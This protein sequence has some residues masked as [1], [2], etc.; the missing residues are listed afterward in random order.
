[1]ADWVESLSPAPDEGT[2]HDQP[3]LAHPAGGGESLPRNTVFAGYEL[4]EELGRGGMGVVYKARQLSLNRTVALKMVLTGRFVSE[5][6]VQRF[7]AEAAAAARL[8]HPNIVT[9]HEVG[10]VD[11]QYFYTMELIEGPSLAQRV[12]AGPLPGRQA[13]HYLLHIARAIHHAHQRGVLHRDLKPSNILLDAD[14]QPHVA[15]FGLA[16]HLGG[17]AAQTRSGALLGTPSYMAPEQASGRVRSLG[18]ACD[19]YGLGAV[20]YELITGQPPFLADTPLETVRLVL[21]REPAPPKL[22]NPDI[23]DDLETICLKCLEKEPGD[24]YPSAAELAADLERYLRGDAIRAG[25]L[26]LFER[27]A[28][29]LGRT[30][31]IDEFHGWGTMLYSFALIVFLEHLLVFLYV[32]RHSPL[33]RRMAVTARI[34][35]F[36]SM[37]VI[38]WWKRRRMLLPTSAAERQLWATWIGYI[39]ACFTVYLVEPNEGPDALGAVL[40]HYPYWAILSGLGFFTMGANYWGWC[41]AFGL[42]FFLLAGLMPLNLEW[43][44]LGFGLWWSL[45]L[46]ALGRHVHR[47]AGKAGESAGPGGSPA[48]AWARGVSREGRS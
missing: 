20:L 19:V 47:L 36:L 12:A 31:P 22:L 13:A 9:V 33:S 2:P 28:R 46:A 27:L 11:G 25:S 34:L 23:D 48:G 44:T 8:R 17:D 16:K 10:E 32:Q 7:K 29:A 3:T 14:D 43:G 40:G 42:G 21:D 39:I 38:F 5:E 1:M 37:G 35:L 18:P 4:L 26:N 24:R 30:H 41:Y 6:E 45:V 15:D